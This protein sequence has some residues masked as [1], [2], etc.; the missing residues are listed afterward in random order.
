MLVER[1]L[2]SSFEDRKS[3]LISRRYGVPGFFIQLLYWN[4]CS[5]RLEMGVS[6]NLWIVVKYLKPLVVYD[7]EC[8]MVM[9]SMK[10]KCAS[11][12]VDL[13]YTNLFC[14]SVGTS[15]FSSCDSVL[16]DSLVFHQVNRCSLRFDWE[17][18]IPL[19][20]MQGNR[21]SSCSEGDVW[22]VF[23][24]CGRHLGYILDLRQGWPFENGVCSAKSGLLSSYDGYLRNLN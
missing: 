16:G 12:W 24:S 20:A 11:T 10:G 5:Y 19:H 6:G 18:G 1:W 21:G 14:I 4:W 3:A 15:V 2:T 22:W 9:D 23:S 8:D 7:V 17:Q 13:R